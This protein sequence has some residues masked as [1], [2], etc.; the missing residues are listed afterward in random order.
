VARGV[1]R[2][3]WR[4]LDGAT[5]ADLT[6]PSDYPAQPDQVDTLPA[7]E[8]SGEGKDYGER[9]SAYLMPPLD[10]DYRFWIAADDSG[11]LWLSSDDDPAHAVLI[12]YTE[13]WTPKHSWDKSPAQAS[14][15]IPLEK[16]KRYYIEVRHKQADQKDNVAVAWQLPGGDRMLIDSGYL[17]TD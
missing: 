9:L 11:E 1:R 13:T 12:A 4:N 2:Q 17:V 15:P 10:G 3:L 6:S 5:I 16:G 14:A 8:T 7:L